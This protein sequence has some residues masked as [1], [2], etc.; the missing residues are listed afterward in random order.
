M[1]FKLFEQECAS[2]GGA[3]IGQREGGK[4]KGRWLGH[5]E[6]TKCRGRADN[7]GPSMLAVT[8]FAVKQKLDG[9]G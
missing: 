1:M 2:C 8:G 7:P 4:S 9:R 5:D 6:C 3:N